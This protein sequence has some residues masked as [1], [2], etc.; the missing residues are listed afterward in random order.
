MK[1]LKKFIIPV[2]VVIIALAA[3]GALY[4]ISNSKLISKDKAGE[5][6][7]K[8]IN[9]QIL[10]GQTT[11]SLVGVSEASG[12]YKVQLKIEDQEYSSYI[13][14]DGKILFAQGYELATEDTSEITKTDKPVVQ[15]FV[16]SFCPYGN[17]AEEAMKPVVE[18]LKDKA[19]IQLHYVIYENYQG[20]GSKYCLDKDNKYCSMHGIQELNQDVREL[21]VQ[22]YQQDKLWNFIKEINAKCTSA[23]VDTCWE[24]PA[25]TTGVDVVKIKTCQKNEALTLLEQESQLNEKYGITGSPQTIINE[26][27]YSGSRSADGY[28][29]AI[30]SAFKSSPQECSQTLSTDGGT[31]SGG[32]E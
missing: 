18:L 29:S 27:E 24:G 12:V 32:C 6:A 1:N 28:K 11:A 5:K 23:N 30:C 14:K 17:Q 7:I 13:T 22:K 2:G 19:D 3:A 26:K 25:K 16:M 15:L 20:G 9:E 10:Q 21:C 8:Y 4:S 31:A